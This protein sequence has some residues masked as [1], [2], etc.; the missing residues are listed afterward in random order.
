MWRVRL[1]WA[2][3]SIWRF[4][5]GFFIAAA[6]FADPALAGPPYLSDDPIP[7]DT[8]HFQIYALAAREHTRE[9]ESGVVGVNYSATPDLQ[10]R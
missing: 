5:L 3:Q 6:A 4:S 8:H 9:G 2:R 1:A 7:T 10:R